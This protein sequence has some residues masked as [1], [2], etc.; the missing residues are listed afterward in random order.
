LIVISLAWLP[1]VRSIS[2]QLFVYI[3]SMQSYMMPP[4]TALFFCGVFSWRVT[5]FG[6]S[7]SLVFGLILG[8]ARFACEAM[9]KSSIGKNWN[10]KNPALYVFTEMNYLYFAFVLFTVSV[11]VTIVFSLITPKKWRQEKADI[12]E[13]TIQW[14]SVFSRFRG[15]KYQKQINE[16]TSEEA[17]KDEELQESQTQQETQKED[18]EVNADIE[19]QNKSDTVEETPAEPTEPIPAIVEKKE[20]S[21]YK[22]SW[23]IYLAIVPCMACLFVYFR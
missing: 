20:L 12:I 16:T 18:T 8:M 21:I 13:Y 10:T 1:V 19:E 23:A 6:S 22:Y 14:D 4:M 2:N 11:V 5:S 9:W 15:N 3:Q 7:I 17:I